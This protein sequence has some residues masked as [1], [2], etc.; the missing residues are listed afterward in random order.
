MIRRLIAPL[1]ALAVLLCA[2]APSQPPRM[3]SQPP[4]PD[5]SDVRP[6]PPEP[7]PEPEPEPEPE[8]PVL[9]QAREILAQMTT[10]EKVGQLFLARCPDRDAAALAEEYRLGGYVL[11]GR[12]FKD[13]TPDQVREN[14][15]SYQAASKIPM[16]I[17]VDEEGGTVVRVSAYTAFRDSRFL[18]P[19]RVYAAGGM[20]AIRADAQEKAA[21]LS[22]LGINVNLAPVCDVSTDENDFIYARSLGQD[23]QTTGEYAAAVVE[24]MNAAGMGCALKHF[25]G[26]GSNQDTHT[27]I[28]IDERD[29]EQFQTCDLLPFQA[30]ID[31]GAPCVLVAH[32]IVTCMDPELPASLSPAVHQLLRDM[33]F[34]GVIVTD[35][36][37]MDGIRQYTGES[38][39]AV[40]AVLAGNDLLCCTSFQ[41]QIP[42]VLAA[43]EDGTI[44]MERL[45]ESVLRVL[46][47]KLRL[48]LIAPM[49]EG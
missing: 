47:W 42:A 11:F 12:D 41:T 46:V 1:A 15:A 35:D 44:S 6:L 31:A 19:R 39:A 2:C 25:P 22:S 29:L 37:T 14:I 24:T 43:V 8:D 38:E 26:Y 7:G 48:G 10:Q 36:L 5:T 13:K 27:G 40:L 23:A 18:S 20:D 17:A 21:L 9:E 32:T 28:A 33:G 30:G 49:P 4:Q 3:E 34:D 45:D 16:L